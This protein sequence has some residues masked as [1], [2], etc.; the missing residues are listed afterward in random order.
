MSD[1]DHIADLLV[2]PATTTRRASM[3]LLL[4]CFRHAE[5]ALKRLSRGDA[6]E[7]TAARCVA[8]RAV[9]EAAIKDAVQ[10]DIAVGSDTLVSWQVGQELAAIVS[11]DSP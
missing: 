6:L 4:A 8:L 9:L 1:L 2:L 11:E 10:R 5:L 3:G 7:R